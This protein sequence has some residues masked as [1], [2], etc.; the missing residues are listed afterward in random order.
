M[1]T[2]RTP[3]A[4]PLPTATLQ[5]L[6]DPQ[7]R[8][9]TLAALGLLTA[10]RH[11]A[12]ALPPEE[13]ARLA[14][15][16][17]TADAALL[18]DDVAFAP[19]TPAAVTAA[20]GLDPADFCGSDDPW[21]RVACAAALLEAG[22]IAEALAQ[23][24]QA[25]PVGAPMV[26]QLRAHTQPIPLTR[27]D[28]GGGLVTV[29]TR[30]APP[31]PDA[32][33]AVQAREILLDLP[34]PREET[35]V[36]RDAQGALT[37]VAG[38]ATVRVLC[39]SEARIGQP[40][41]VTLRVDDA[42][43][44]LRIED[45]GVVTV[46]VEAGPHEV[47]LS[48]PGPDHALGV[49]VETGGAALPP[50][51]LRFAMEVRADRPTTLQVAG[52]GV[53]EVEVL[54]GAVEAQA[55]PTRAQGQADDALLIAITEDGPQTLTLRGQG[56]ALV[57][58]RQPR[59]A[60]PPA[61]PL[62]P[63][64]PPAEVPAVLDPAL[65]LA[66]ERS[67]LAL[68]TLAQA[69]VPG[70][71]PTLVLGLTP[72][73]ERLGTSTEWWAAS[74]GSA[75][76]L[77]SQGERWLRA[78]GW[79]RGPLTRPVDRV[80]G[81]LELE[82]GLRLP[83]GWA[84]MRLDLAAAGRA[85]YRAGHGEVMAFMAWDTR[86]GPDLKLRGSGFGRLGLYTEAPGP[87]RVD[88]KAWNALGARYPVQGAFQL[89]AIATPLR[90]LRLEGG[91]ELHPGLSPVG[92]GAEIVD[93]RAPVGAFLELDARLT[94]G[95]VLSTELLLNRHFDDG[96]VRVDEWGP[97][98]RLALDH[99]LWNPAGTR[100]VQLWAQVEATP[101]TFTDA[102][103]RWAGVPAT[104]EG[105]AGVRVLLT[106]RRSLSDLPPYREVFRATRGAP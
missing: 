25:G 46:P 44:D 95:T 23:A 64:P 66:A 71:A 94:P 56:A 100:R 27:P 88:P 75:E 9:Q 97:R 76:A 45:G 49:R 53:V 68:Q 11:H 31:G 63:P 83:S 69:P 32:P 12:A 5:D 90:E 67:A 102:G 34:W 58:W 96:L 54:A 70:R 92:A 43:A 8:P 62:D 84:G 89:S 30:P 39:R 51:A 7:R 82:G 80:A 72:L 33:L 21:A 79:A 47:E 85:G 52:P 74:E 38:P 22:R 81:G 13:A 106:R 24:Q 15:E 17:P 48:P 86:V 50:Q 99:V 1:R 57:W 60:E 19:L 36:V 101:L 55:G 28:A 42:R 14:P 37:R 16:R 61:E 2:P 87:V 4:P 104:L 40:C 3:P 20:T 35:L 73:Y 77:A 103:L 18:P 6:H 65:A 10:A 78:E 26:R 93:L 41:A 98:T 29:V 105:R 59:A 91:L